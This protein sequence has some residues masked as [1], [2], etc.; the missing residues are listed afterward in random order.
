MTIRVTQSYCFDWI[1]VSGVD[2]S[3]L[4][5]IYQNPP[6]KL[7]ESWNLVQMFPTPWGTTKQ[8]SPSIAGKKNLE[9]V[10]ADFS[11]NILVLFI[12]K[13]RKKDR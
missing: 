12:K 3:N 13:K 9:F 8:K 1:R 10:M 6:K 7:L 11:Q 2:R 4:P 5:K